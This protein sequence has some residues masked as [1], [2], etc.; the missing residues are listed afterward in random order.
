M[1]LP[2]PDMW[3]KFEDDLLDSSG[4]NRHASWQGTAYPFADFDTEG[5]GRGV[6]PQPH[7]GTYSPWILVP[8]LSWNTSGWTLNIFVKVHVSD[9]GSNTQFYI[10]AFGDY[11]TA[12][13]I[14]VIYN[15]INNR[16]Y[17]NSYNISTYM[18]DALTPLDE[19]ML[20]LRYNGHDGANSNV[21]LFT[22]GQFYVNHVIGTTY[23]IPYEDYH[24][25]AAGENGHELFLCNNLVGDFRRYNQLLTNDQITELY[26]DFTGPTPSEEIY[27]SN[28]SMR[29][30]DT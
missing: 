21:D 15:S 28:V 1:A 14:Q 12:G 25:I 26:Q 19:V 8:N 7:E 20:T 18:T 5:V 6:G 10:C 29:G 2:N 23:N 22:N 30:L 13:I 11:Y 4:Y 3:Y 9:E 24:C 17:F 27:F 16:I